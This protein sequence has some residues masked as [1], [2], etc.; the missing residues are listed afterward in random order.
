MF[1]LL[2]KIFEILVFFVFCILILNELLIIKIWE[3]F[4]F[5]FLSMKLN[6]FLL[7]LEKLIFLLI[8]IFGIYLNKF[9]E[10]ILFFCLFKGLFVNIV[11]WIFWIVRNLKKGFILLNKFILKFVCFIYR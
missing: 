10:W 6:V 11:N 5:I 3:G 4:I 9:N 2:I 8:Y 1:I 7:G